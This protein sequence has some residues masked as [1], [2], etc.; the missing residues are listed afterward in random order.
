MLQVVDR[1]CCGEKTFP[2]D[3]MLLLMAAQRFTLSV[4]LLL[5]PL[6]TIRGLCCVL[7][8]VFPQCIA[9]PGHA[10]AYAAIVSPFFLLPS[11]RM[12]ESH[13]QPNS[14]R[15]QLK[16]QEVEEECKDRQNQDRNRQ[17]Y[18]AHEQLFKCRFR[19]Y[20]SEF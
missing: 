3:T 15:D 8:F 16:H 2:K 7:L 4:S 14:T 17:A 10:I 9:G 12:P 13:C 19:Q 1:T 5:L 18:V 20:H 6:F 11:D